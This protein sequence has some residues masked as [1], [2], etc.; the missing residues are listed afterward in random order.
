VGKGFL[1]GAKVV[2]GRHEASRLWQRDRF[3][4]PPAVKNSLPE[5]ARTKKKARA[6]IG[7]G[8]Q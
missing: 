7:P 3:E 5:A 1:W 6:A 8:F 2:I 4:P